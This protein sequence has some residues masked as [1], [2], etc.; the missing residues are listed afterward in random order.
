M[1]ARYYHP[2]FVPTERRGTI[3]ST[4]KDSAHILPRIAGK[5]SLNPPPDDVPFD[6]TPDFAGSCRNTTLSGVRIGVPRNAFHG[7]KSVED[8]AFTKAL[9]MLTQVGAQT[10]ENTNLA[11][12]EE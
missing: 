3:S 7:F 11:A 1:F 10:V 8:G 9:V 5:R 6:T 4:V 2:Y 12:A